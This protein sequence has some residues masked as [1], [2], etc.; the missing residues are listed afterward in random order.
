M[1]QEPRRP[2]QGA[3]FNRPELEASLEVAK[4]PERTA[5]TQGEREHKIEAARQKLEREPVAEANEVAKESTPKPKASGLS[6]KQAYID[7]MA[8][9]QRHLPTASRAFSKMIHSPIMEATSEVAGK[10]VMRPSVTLGAS[11]TA[12]LV[13]G[14]TYLFAKHYGFA[15]SGSE[16]LFSLLVGAVI[17]LLV[18]G[19]AKLFRPRA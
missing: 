16:I 19:I 2:E 7:T 15:L 18:E 9:I 14:F 3:E 11:S 6:R 17:G 4:S 10:T 5:E 12:L 13:G 1:E 8:S